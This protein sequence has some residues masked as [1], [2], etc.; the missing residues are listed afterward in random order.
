M[1]PQ[2]PTPKS[3][4]KPVLLLA[5]SALALGLAGC[6]VDNRPLLARS[7]APDYAALPQPGAPYDP[8]AAAP[9]YGAQPYPASYLPPERAYPYAERA[10]GYD[11]AFYDAPPTYGFAYGDEEPWVWETAD[12]GYM[13]AEPYDDEYRFYYYEPGADYPYFVRDADYGY[14]GARLLEPRLR[15]LFHL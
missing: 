14:A 10:Y 7:D 5:A 13:F 2:S 4:S 12:D 8:G 6:K 3:L 9:S 15:P 11:R 1:T